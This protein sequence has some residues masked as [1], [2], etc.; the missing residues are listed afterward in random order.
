MIEL[1]TQKRDKIAEHCQRLNVCRLE[2]F[3][4]AA[5]GDFSEER[6][7]IDFLVEFGEGHEHLDLLD[8]YLNLADSLEALFERKVDLV[9]ARPFK[10][11]YFRASVEATKEPV[12]AL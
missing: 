4:S 11:P 10:N 7:D 12:Y 8:R 6:S 2:V 3:G 9:M 1:I 5:N